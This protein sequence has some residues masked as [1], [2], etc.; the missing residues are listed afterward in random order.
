V[1][2]K[3]PPRRP[4]SGRQLAIAAVAE[5]YALPDAGQRDRLISSFGRKGR[6]G[7]FADRVARMFDWPLAQAVAELAKLE[8]APAWAPSPL[9]CAETIPL[10]A[11]ARYPG[12]MALFARFQPGLGFPEHVHPD[13]EITFVLEGAFRD[14]SGVLVG[15]GD[16]LVL[17]AGSRHAFQVTPQAPCIAAVIAHGGIEI[18]TRPPPAGG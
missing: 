18:V 3:T 13:G 1:S 12:A 17:G 7:I 6:F 4:R 11:G 8:S 10:V 16:E 2:G 15:R 9:P 5:G 14:A